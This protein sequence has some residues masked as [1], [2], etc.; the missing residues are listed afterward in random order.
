MEPGPT[1]E[2]QPLTYHERKTKLVLYG[3]LSQSQLISD[4]IVIFCSESWLNGIYV[5]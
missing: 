1:I 2:T 3:T 4:S 5:F